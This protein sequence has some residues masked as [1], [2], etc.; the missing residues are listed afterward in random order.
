VP[1]SDE[2]VIAAGGTVPV[3]KVE[4]AGRD[5]DVEGDVEDWSDDGREGRST[6]VDDDAAELPRVQA[7]RTMSARTANATSAHRAAM[8]LM[9]SGP[10]QVID[11]EA[12]RSP[13]KCSSIC[14]QDVV[15]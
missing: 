9:V 11:I 3:G 15:V 13:K 7:T 1:R 8:S 6:R 12:A 2:V 10:G 4:V 14:A 5:G